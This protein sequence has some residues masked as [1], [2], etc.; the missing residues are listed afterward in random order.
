MVGD[1]STDLL[2][3]RN[4]GVRSVLVLTGYGR[5][6]MKFRVPEIGLS[7]DHVAEDLPG[8]VDWILRRERREREDR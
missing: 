5:G 4:A 7:P 6:E 3:A 2:A 1:S 8:A